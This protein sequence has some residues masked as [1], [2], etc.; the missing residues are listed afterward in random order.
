[1][2]LPPMIILKSVPLPGDRRADPMV[3][4]RADL[5]LMV[6]RAHVDFTQNGKAAANESAVV[7]Q[8]PSANT[9]ECTVVHLGGGQTLFVE[10]TPNEVLRLLK[11]ASSWF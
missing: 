2:K 11:Q 3:A 6:Q 9:R 1:M 7:R 4:V 5:V 10:N 8:L